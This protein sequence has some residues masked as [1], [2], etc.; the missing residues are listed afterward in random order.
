[1]SELDAVLRDALRARLL[2]RMG[3]AVQH[4]LNS[5]VQGLYLCL[6]VALLGVAALPEGEIARTQVE[7][8]VAIARK[9]L[10]R[11]ERSSRSLL[12]NAGILEDEDAL[13]DLAELTRELTRHFAT[14]AAM[15]K[16]R[17]VVSLPAEPLRVRG[18]RGEIGQAVLACIVAALDQVNGGGC[19]EVEVR[20][21][22]DRAVVDV[23]DDPPTDGAA[24]GSADEFTLA[25]IAH[26]IARQC[27]ESR[28]GE[29]VT[30]E[31][32]PARRRATCVRLPL[33]GVSI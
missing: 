28:G 32:G 24:A 15:R 23:L 6:D 7:K 33:D 26:R 14:E 30:E 16:V 31:R 1:M 19:V 2:R 9:E 13:F 12:A 25:S 10:A 22:G 4:E 8:A 29:F 21:D 20:I 3:H 5:P 27:V 11:L 18:P 17:L